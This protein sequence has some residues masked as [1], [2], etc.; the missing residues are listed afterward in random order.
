V[1]VN[2]QSKATGWGSSS[3]GAI[4]FSGTRLDLRNV[5]LAGNDSKYTGDGLQ[6]NGGAV[7]LTN[8]TV[9]DNGGEGVR[10]AGGTVTVKDSILWG[11]GVD[12][13]GGVT[14]AWSCYSNSTDHVNGGNNTNANP[15]FVDTNYY[16]LKSQAG[17][18]VGGYF[19]GGTW[20]NSSASSPCIDAGDRASDY[21]REPDPNGRRINMGAYGNTAV[22]SKSRLLGT[23]FVTW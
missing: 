11:N 12:S 21:S 20:A 6:V 19:S 7:S 13:T 22:A 10:L 23:L 17:N 4:Y 5:L 18:Y 3:G 8:V 2:N 14:I 15:L 1:I 16:H 9:A